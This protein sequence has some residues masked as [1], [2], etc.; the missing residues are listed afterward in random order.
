MIVAVELPSDVVMQL[1][2]PASV[3]RQLIEALAIENYRLERLTRD[4]VGQLLGLDYWQTDAFLAE[5]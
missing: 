1:G 3:Q 5:Y 4:Q 2:G